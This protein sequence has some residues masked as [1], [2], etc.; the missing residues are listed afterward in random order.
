MKSLRKNLLLVL[1]TLSVLFG[2][3]LIHTQKTEAK[4]TKVYLGKYTLTAYCPCRSCSGGHGSNTA[5]GKKA[6]QGRTIA[7]DTRKIKLG[8]KIHIN[9][10]T[11]TA[12]DVGG[13][14]KGNRIDVYFTSHKKALQFG[15]KKN[16]KVYKVTTKASY[17]SDSS[18]KKVEGD[19]ITTTSIDTDVDIPKFNLSY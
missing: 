13:A 17:D 14:I 12:E 1:L 4:T 11:Y 6:K 10:H 3:T 19:S 7:V 5:S 9:G 15:K 8:T 18:S 2:G 16:V